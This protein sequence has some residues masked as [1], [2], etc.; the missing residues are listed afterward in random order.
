MEEYLRVGCIANV[1]GVHGEVKVYPTTDVISRF[2]NLKE[3]WLSKPSGSSG[4][5]QKEPIRTL[6]H[7]EGVKYFKGLVIL[8]F[9]EYDDRTK[10]EGIK[11]FELYVDRANAVPLADD[12]FFY[13]DIYDADVF[14]DTGEKL[15]KVTD[16]L[17]TGANDCFVV[18]T[19]DGKEVLFPNVKECVTE[20]NPEEK[21][22]KVHVMKGLMDL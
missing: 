18:K 6:L 8:K 15:G 9:K 22:I 2:D 7:V 20:I 4:P 5:K 19:T 10:A 12:E 14:A 13:C 17:E 16:V 11:G 21:Y 3:V 1:H